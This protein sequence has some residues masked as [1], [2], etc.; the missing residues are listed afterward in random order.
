MTYGI[1]G[2]WLLHQLKWENGSPVD[3]IVNIYVS[4]VQKKYKD[5]VVVF[6][7][8]GET[9]SIKHHVHA[10]RTKGNIVSYDLNIAPKMPISCDRETFLVNENNKKSLIEL[11]STKMTQNKIVHVVHHAKRMHTPL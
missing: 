4:H 2:G 11:I 9:L 3:T 6:D 10:R 8:Y 1:D 7:G 5:A